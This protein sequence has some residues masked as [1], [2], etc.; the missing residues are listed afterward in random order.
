MSG[1][2]RSVI[3]RAERLLC[4]CCISRLF[5]PT[6]GFYRNVFSMWKWFTRQI[7]TPHTQ[8][9]TH[10]L[11][12]VTGRRYSSQ[13]LWAEEHSC[14][15]QLKIKIMIMKLVQFEVKQWSES[16]RAEDLKVSSERL[17]VASL[18]QTLCPISENSR[19][20]LH[21]NRTAFHDP[22]TKEIKM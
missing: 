19:Q 14:P 3:R 13:E 16:C 10:M 21:W 4:L 1:T 22:E 12:M 5:Q 17:P 18:K 8:R 7:N 20:S 9:Y 11:Q 15:S 2:S 6:S